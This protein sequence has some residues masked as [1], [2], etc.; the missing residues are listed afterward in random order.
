MAT[1]FDKQKAQDSL[2]M[3]KQLAKT[4]TSERSKNTFNTGNMVAFSYNAKNQDAIFDKS[5][6]IIT[7]RQSRSYV[8]GLNFHWCPLPARKILVKYIFKLNQA[9]I[10]ANKPL[11][12][13]YKML[14]PAIARLR[15][16]YVIRLY[17]KSRISR[18]CLI[19]PQEY[20]LKA[21]DLPA[22]NFNNGMSSAQ[23][24]TWAKNKSKVRM[25]DRKPR[26]K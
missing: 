25:I 2:K 12:I 22:E 19:I 16:M 14:V 13:T 15:L 8:L 4:R 23:L 10:R 11:E 20:Y 1:P 3:F 26:K 21:V 7:I 9:N 17:I 24:Y 6:L 18:R 5:P